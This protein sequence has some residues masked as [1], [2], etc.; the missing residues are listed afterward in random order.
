MH[1]NVRFNS[2]IADSFSIICNNIINLIDTIPNVD[3]TLRYNYTS[4]NLTLDVIDDLNRYIP[5]EYRKKIQFFPRKVW[6][7]KESD[8]NETSLSKLIQKA[9]DSGYSVNTSYDIA[10]GFCY[11]EK[12]HFNTIFY[13]GTV[14]KCSNIDLSMARGIL[15]KN[16]EIKWM[17]DIEE[18]S[19][20]VFNTENECSECRYLPICLGLC[21]I[22]RRNN[23]RYNKPYLCNFHNREKYFNASILRYANKFL[24]SN[25]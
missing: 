11:A 3:I 12:K 16:G 8:I 15:D 2:S 4:K 23:L 18:Y 6:Q 9:N 13:N 17:H 25:R 24:K 7:S 20:T 21:P 10:H 22:S 14:D 19:K 1:N 5:N